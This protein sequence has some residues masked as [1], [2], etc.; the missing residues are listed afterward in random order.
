MKIAFISFYSGQIDRGVEVGTANLSSRLVRNH[1]V[2]LF[3]AGKR[4][5]PGVSTVVL[6][7]TKWPEDSSSS[8]F[9][10]LYLD[11]YSRR[12]ALF[13]LRL[14]HFFFKS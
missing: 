5:I 14:T 11:Y 4:V 6:P 13:T 9:R 7:E 2:T 3:Q 8:F 1:R 10:L 12:I